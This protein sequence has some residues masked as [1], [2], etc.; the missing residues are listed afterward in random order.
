VSNYRGY[1]WSKDELTDSSN[2]SPVRA[3][4]RAPDCSGLYRENG[5]FPIRLFDLTRGTGY[6]L[7]IYLAG[8]MGSDRV[9][10]IERIA[11]SLNAFEGV[12]IVPL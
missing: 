4:D 5:K 7:V 6:V 8:T 2:D 1:D 11:N 10:F 3:G 12:T 9:D